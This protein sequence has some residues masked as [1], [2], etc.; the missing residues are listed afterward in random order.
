MPNIKY[1]K[2][3][4]KS[5]KPTMIKH[6]AKISIMEWKLNY[7]CFFFLIDLII[8]LLSNPSH[9]RTEGKKVTNKG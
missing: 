8:N 4:S 6:I 1:N 9:K 2:A 7:E 5:W 3:L